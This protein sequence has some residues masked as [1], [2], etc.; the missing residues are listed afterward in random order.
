MW[1]SIV[2]EMGSF[3]VRPYMHRVLSGI[4]PVCLSD[5]VASIVATLLAV[6]VSGA[7]QPVCAMFEAEPRLLNQMFQAFD[8]MVY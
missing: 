2:H 6:N 7:S 8:G 4:E 5:S 1:S 3:H